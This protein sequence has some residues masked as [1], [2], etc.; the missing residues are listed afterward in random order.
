MPYTSDPTG[1][2]PSSPAVRISD[3]CLR[4]YPGSGHQSSPSA[5]PDLRLKRRATGHIP[6]LRVRR[7]R[8]VYSRSL[9]RKPRLPVPLCIHTR[10][11]ERAGPEGP[12]LPST[13]SDPSHPGNLSLCDPDGSDRLLYSADTDPKICNRLSKKT[14]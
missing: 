3:H 14:R 7:T 2:M 12:W 11:S 10:T 13:C 8:H 9:L 6:I 4:H 1:G 5:R